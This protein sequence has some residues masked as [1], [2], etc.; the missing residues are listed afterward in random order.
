MNLSPSPSSDKYEPLLLIDRVNGKPV[1]ADH[2]SI[3]RAGWNATPPIQNWMRELNSRLQSH[4]MG[5]VFND[6]QIK[7]SEED[8]IF[9]IGSDFQLNAEMA[10]N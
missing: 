1:R 7:A 4:G 3:P 9:D 8:W 2:Y 10:F 6:E 5:V